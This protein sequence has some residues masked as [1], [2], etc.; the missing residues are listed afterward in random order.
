MASIEKRSDCSYRLTV[1]LGYSNGK[2]IKKQKTVKLDP[3][4]KPKQVEKE[5]Q[6]QAVLFE[7]AVKEGV[8]LEPSHFTVSSFAEKWLNEHGKSLANKTRLRYEKILRG[9]VSRA[10]GHLKLDQLK[11]LHLLEFYQNLQEIGIRE[12]ITYIATPELKELI[13]KQAIELNK[14]AGAADITEKTLTGILSGKPTTTARN[15]TDALN[16]K[17]DLKVKF[18]KM[19]IPASDLKPLS[20]KTVIYYHRVLSVM[21]ADAVRWEMMRENPC[22]K[23]QPPKATQKEMSCLDEEGI[24]RLLECLESEDI[25]TQ[26]IITLALITGCRRGEICG[27]Q[28]EH[29]DLEKGVINIKQAAT[30]TPEAGTQVKL[31]KTKAGIRQIAIPESVVQLLKQYRKWWLERKIK[32]GDL[33]QREEKE[34]Q[35]DNWKDSEWL[36]AT[37]DGHIMHPDTIT[38]IF[39]KFLNRHQ[40][41][42]IRFH[43][44][45]HGAATYLIHSGLNVR[46]VAAR[47]GHANPDI[48]LRVY[49]HALQ[50]AD[51]QAASIMEN[52]F[53]KDIP[54]DQ[55]QA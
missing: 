42:I 19:F 31:P 5:L 47:M 29:I 10:L 14:L 51:Q 16:K 45:R 50:S 41:P 48:T 49:A 1:S 40:L 55:K 46:A 3:G 26:I 7:N 24:S 27:L 36:L 44:L 28:W 18:I 23:V 6:R 53:K 38:S 13:N 9:R 12:D 21:F 32:L 54:A 15:I 11:P 17:F 52:L 20:N 8:F 35:G 39:K 43:D 37:W 25:K 22:L 4:L 2:K 33:W 30:Y 34:Q